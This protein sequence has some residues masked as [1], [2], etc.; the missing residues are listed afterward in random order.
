MKKLNITRY[1]CASYLAFI[2]YASGS[3]VIPI[4][5]VQLAKDLNFPLEVAGGKSAGGWLHMTRSIAICVTMVMSAFISARFGHRRPIGIAVLLIGLGLAACALTPTYGFLVLALIIVG[6]G[7]G[8]I[9]ALATPFVQDLHDD[10]PS[11]YVNFTHGFWALGVFFSTLAFG[12]LIR[13]GIHWRYVL[14]ITAA[15]AVPPTLLLLLPSRKPYP[16]KKHTISFHAV[17]RQAKDV[18]AVPRFWRYFVAMFF[19]GG[20]EFCLTFWCASVIQLNFKGSAMAGGIGTAAFAIG[21]FI[22]RTGAGVF[23]KHKYLKHLIIVTGLGASAIAFPIPYMTTFA[24]GGATWVLPLFHVVLFLAG[25]CTAPFWPSIQSH[26]VDRMPKQDSTMIFILLS[27]AG[28]PGAGAFTLL[29][30]YVGDRYGFP[31]SYYLVPLCFLDLTALI[32]VKDNERE[33]SVS[34]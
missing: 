15:L 7:E 33:N 20:G 16:E 13:Y 30:G 1:D 24:A 21:M 31:V 28:I 17:I 19:A 14:G 18:C 22:G 6:F 25:L 4:V 26:A 11:R 29:M 34:I 9:E 2:T 12:A 8:V 5:L 3:L 32:G 27:C 10:E 23:V